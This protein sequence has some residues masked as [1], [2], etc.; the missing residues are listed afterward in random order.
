[1]RD[2]LIT[3]FAE[4]L[5][6]ENCQISLFPEVWKDWKYGNLKIHRYVA[7]K[8]YMFLGFNVFLIC[9]YVCIYAWT[10]IHESISIYVCIHTFMYECRHTYM[11]YLCKS[12]CM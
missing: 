10:H 11:L 8:L 2:V 4:F 9:M 3:I 6:F 12:A 7:L 1:M 5:Y